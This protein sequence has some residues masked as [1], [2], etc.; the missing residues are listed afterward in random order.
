MKKFLFLFLLSLFF[1]LPFLKA[2]EPVQ[3]P[4]IIWIMAD[5]MGYGD[6]GCYGQKHILTPNI[7]RMAKEGTRFT[8]CYAG[9]TVCAPSRSVLMTGQHTGHTY[10]RVNG[11]QNKVANAVK[12][13][14]SGLYRI[15]LRESDITVAEVL[16]KAGYVTG[17]T[18]KWG[19]GEPGTSGTPLKKGF[20]EWLGYLNQNRAHNH[21]PEYIWKN[22]DKKVELPGNKDNQEKQYTHDLFTKFSL[23]F[24]TKHKDQPFFLY[25][26][27]CV[28]HS[29]FQVPDLA[30]YKDKP[31][32][33]NEKIYAAMIT[34]MDRDIGLLIEK[35]K[36][37]GIDKNTCIFFCSDNGA[38]DRYD[39][40][41]NSSGILSGQKRS[42]TDGGLRTPMVVRWPGKVPAGQVN[43]NN[44]Y[45]ADF[46][47]TAA[48]MVG[49]E[50]PKHI[51]GLNI[52]PTLLGKKQNLNQRTL[53]WEFH[54]RGFQQAALRGDW[55]AIRDKIGAELKI[56]NL[57]DDPAE[58][59]NLAKK[60]PK[61]VK[62][63][64]I[65]FQTARTESEIITIKN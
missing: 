27:Y 6:A 19:L 39:G 33:K 50:S 17:M 14:G 55:K 13:I 53:Y 48:A 12:G 18:G 45:F 60:Y 9:S 8:R 37:L 24:V 28:P 31:W 57:K 7:D 32:T 34:R 59:I 26:P 47:P 16:K 62:E 56:Y 15:P 1:Y 5:D 10:V 29:R 65:Y 23:D 35:I 41:F 40:R 46:L 25:L 63:F 21:Y 61:K 4:N 36:E 52:L 64:E 51:D 3:K 58:K 20:D 44:W 43:D 22:L 2:R 38:A 30:P 11:V 54:E 49:V 42:M